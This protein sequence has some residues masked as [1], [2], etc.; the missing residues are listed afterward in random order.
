[1]VMAGNLGQGPESSVQIYSGV[2]GVGY[3]H[4]GDQEMILQA[5]HMVFGVDEKQ[6]RWAMPASPNSRV[7][8]L[9][10]LCL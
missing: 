5:K 6:E 3:Y 8:L 10:Q 9:P 4:A 2:M 1:M 7:H